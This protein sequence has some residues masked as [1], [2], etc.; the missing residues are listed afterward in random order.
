MIIEQQGLTSFCR[1]LKL[2][3]L[4]WPVAWRCEMR[5]Y[6]FWQPIPTSRRA[7]TKTSK[8]NTWHQLHLVPLCRLLPCPLCAVEDRAW[9]SFPSLAI[10]VWDV[11]HVFHFLPVPM[12]TNTTLDCIFKQIIFSALSASK[13]CILLQGSKFIYSLITNICLYLD[14]SRQDIFR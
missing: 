13:L 10:F 3:K 5:Y 12:L 7:K 8:M 1:R 4:E 14:V 11:L 9:R 6:T 2:V